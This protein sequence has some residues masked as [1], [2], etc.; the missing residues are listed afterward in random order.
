M[1]RKGQSWPVFAN[2]VLSAPGHM[3]LRPWPGSPLHRQS[4]V[5]STEALYSVGFPHPPPAL[6]RVGLPRVRAGG[7][8]AMQRPGSRRG[9]VLWLPCSVLAQ[10]RCPPPR[11]GP[12]PGWRSRGLPAAHCTHCRSQPLTS[13]PAPLLTAS[14]GVPGDEELAGEGLR[15]GPLMC[16]PVQRNM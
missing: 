8:L 2:K 4:R 7:G 6:S 16:Q 13:C 15:H 11:R 3:P 5:F 10:Q 12:P 1:P 9:F 14:E